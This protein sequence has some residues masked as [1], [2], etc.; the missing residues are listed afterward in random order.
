[1]NE[2]SITGNDRSFGCAIVTYTDTNSQFYC[3]GG[4]LVM[5]KFSCF[6]VARTF[7]EKNWQ[8]VH[9]TKI[10]AKRAHPSCHAG[11]NARASL[12]NLNCTQVTKYTRERST[13]ALKPIA[14]VTR[15]PEQGFSGNTRTYRIGR[16][17][18]VASWCLPPPQ[19]LPRPPP[20]QNYHFYSVFAG[21]LL[22]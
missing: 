18:R 17:R 14:N 1:M 22:K 20:A 5:L 6:P 21:K 19:P 3:L 10:A 15:S 12:K 7:C 2:S 4:V 8:C 13:L 16:S 11:C 9:A